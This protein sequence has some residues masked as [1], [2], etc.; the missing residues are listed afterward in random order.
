LEDGYIGVYDVNSKKVRLRR[1]S[2][3]SLLVRTGSSPPVLFSYEDGDVVAG[4]KLFF[5]PAASVA[6]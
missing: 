1:L 3:W 6:S 2:V 5:S 4:I